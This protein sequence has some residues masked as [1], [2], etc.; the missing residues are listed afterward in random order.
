MAL[1]PC[2]ALFQFYVADGQ[3]SCQLYQ[4]SADIFLGVPFNIA[5]YALLTLMVAQVVR[6]PA[7]R[8]RA[9]P[10]RRPPL[11]ATTSNRRACSCRASRARCRRMR[12]NPD[13]NRPLR[14]PLR[15]LHARRLRPASADR[16][17]GR[18]MRAPRDLAAPGG[19]KMLLALVDDAGNISGERRLASA[20]FSGVDAT[21]CG[22]SCAE[23]GRSAIRG[24]DGACLAVAGPVSEDGR[25]AR[26]T[27]LPWQA[28]A[29]VL[30]HLLGAPLTLAND[31]AA[32]AA[33]I[34]TLPD[35]Q[36]IT[37]QPGDP[38]TDGVRL[39]IGAGTG[40]GMATIVMG[41]DTFR[42][43]PSEG[44]HV[45]FA[46]ANDVQDAFAAFLRA[47]QGRATA[48]RAISGMGLLHPVSFPGTTYARR[49]AG[50][51]GG[52]R[53]VGRHRRTCAG[54]SCQPGAADG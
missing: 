49:S 27:N 16:G 24:I 9:Y 20:D 54:G 3:L 10:R 52:G 19:T 51:S 1:P 28:E 47:G 6:L 40:L 37:L 30:E 14:L 53:S 35:D 26:F 2:H 18:G 50:S 7:R 33:G 48:E 8:L 46:P 4:R 34:A 5:S 23:V 45:G 41:G 44:G 21:C 25:Q 17:A 29:A 39:A 12:L 38:L 36:R 15:G 42:I 22:N 11:L 43:L 32:V 31:F 13:G